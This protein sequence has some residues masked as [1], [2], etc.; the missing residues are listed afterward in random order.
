MTGRHC[1][2]R[3]TSAAS[4]SLEAGRPAK[5]SNRPLSAMSSPRASSRP[6]DAG[7]RAADADPFD[8]E[9]LE[10][11]TGE[12]RPADQHVDRRLPASRMT[13]ATSCVVFNS[14]VKARRRRLPRSSAEP[15][16]RLG[17][18]A[19]LAQ[20]R[21]LRAVKRPFRRCIDRRA[22]GAQ[23]STASLN[24]KTRRVAVAAVI[25]DR[26]AGDAGAT[27]SLASHR[28]PRRRSRSRPRNPH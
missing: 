15:S 28:R 22:G 19:C 12:A 9:V 21:R 6:G 10:L 13:S 25:L 7:E 24:G 18:A 11:A 1:E 23:C 26:K 17:K 2:G 3:S 8:A 4:I 16:Q 27:Q 5:A 14:G 20:D